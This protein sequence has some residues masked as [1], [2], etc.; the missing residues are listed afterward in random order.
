[1]LDSD[2]AFKVILVGNQK[3]GKSVL[4]NYL[5]GDSFNEM[6][7]QTIGV[8]FAVLRR[9]PIKFL[10]WDIAGDEKFK[11][12]TP[13]YYRSADI[14]IYALDSTEAVD[15]NKIILK[16]FQKEISAV[17]PVSNCFNIIVFTKSDHNDS[18]IS[19]FY[20]K[21][22]DSF[23]VPIIVSSAKENKGLSE[24]N[25]RLSEFS[26]LLITTKTIMKKAESLVSAIE[27]YSK[28]LNKKDSQL[29][30]NKST[31]LEAI[32]KV[33]RDGGMGLPSDQSNV[34]FLSLDQIS[35]IQKVIKE[36][37]AI[38]T[39]HR[40]SSCFNWFFN[41]F[42][43]SRLARRITSNELVNKLEAYL[44]HSKDEVGTIRPANDL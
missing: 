4:L 7:V 1:M 25:E 32:A 16:N 13:A 28:S 12:I 11:R 14:I 19:E 44:D 36:N 24:I 17:C 38:I 40:H 3:V 29:A 6:Y 22:F 39:Q 27:N 21:K 31:A 8:D 33:C 42:T 9:D 23:K 5:R 26:Q 34:R 37:K 35:E 41:L 15:K 2:K 10:I 43:P 20:L 30:K 18:K